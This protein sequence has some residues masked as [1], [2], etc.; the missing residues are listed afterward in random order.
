RSADPES[1]PAAAVGGAAV[2][3]VRRARRCGRART[4]AAIMNMLARDIVAAAGS[5]HVL[6]R[7]Y[8]TRGVLRLKDVGAWKYAADPRT[9]MLCCAFAV[10]DQPV[11]LWLPGQPP[12]EEFLEAAVNPAWLFSAHNDA[13]ESSVEHFILRRRHGFPKLPLNRHRCTMAMALAL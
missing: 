3:T 6:H 2:G 9:E 5:A 1:R 4:G 8:E 13:F 10:D 7:D 12:P 11:Q